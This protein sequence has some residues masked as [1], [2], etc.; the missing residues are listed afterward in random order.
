MGSSI[1][2]F[3]LKLKAADH[4]DLL[5]GALFFLLWLALTIRW[6]IELG[7]FSVAFLEPVTLFVLGIFMLNAFSP[8]K[9]PKIYINSVVLIL[10]FFF[11]W[12]VSARTWDQNW[13]HGLSDLR[14]WGIPIVTF[15]TILSFVR[16]GWRKWAILLIPIALIHSLLSIYQRFTDSFRPFA[17]LEAIYKLDFSGTFRPS[18]AVGLFEHPNSLA[19][20]LMIAIMVAIGWMLEQPGLIRKCVP[21]GIILLFGVIL[22]WT[23]AKAE[24]ITLILMIFLFFS[25]SYIHSSRKFIALYSIC[26]VFLLAGSWYAIEQWPEKFSTIW[27]R[28]DLWHSALQ[29]LSKNPLIFLFG[30]GDIAFAAAAN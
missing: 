16:H 15:I 3:H 12:I 22:Y 26:V 1:S 14:D 20:F 5:L 13:T 18:I 2:K 4:S 30:N 8:R 29:I 21:T 6:R 24:I 10:I 17:S 11:M 25:I 7:G 28:I 23:Y 27:W 19:V 9:K